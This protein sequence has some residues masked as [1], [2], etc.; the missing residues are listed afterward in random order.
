MLS[1]NLPL[2]HLVLIRC[3]AMSV[4][5]IFCFVLRLFVCIVLPVEVNKVVH[6]DLS[7]LYEVLVN[8]IKHSVSV[9]VAMRVLS[10]CTS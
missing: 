4:F 3:S 1:G 6:F 9:C 8:E 5:F 10:K 2:R 7:P